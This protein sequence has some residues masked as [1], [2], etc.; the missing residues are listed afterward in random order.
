MQGI[1]NEV[2]APSTLTGVLQR[3]QGNG[4]LTRKKDKEDNR[5]SLLFLTAAGETIVGKKELTVEGV[6]REALADESPGSVRK[7]MNVLSHLTARLK[8]TAPDEAGEAPA[9]RSKR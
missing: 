4:L 1:S 6:V 7:T 5:R 3:L 2:L 9:K 8:A